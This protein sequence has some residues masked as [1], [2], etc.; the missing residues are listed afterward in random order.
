MELVNSLSDTHISV[1]F[2][3][4]KNADGTG[5]GTRVEIMLP[6]INAFTGQNQKTA[7]Q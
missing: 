2:T 7:Q 4:L 5:T 3:D 1:H 6:L